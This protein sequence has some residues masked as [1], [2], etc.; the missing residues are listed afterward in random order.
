[1]T[2]ITI[3]FE[4][5]AQSGTKPHCDCC[6]RTHMKNT[7]VLKGEEMAPI[8]LGVI[9]AGKWFGIDLT[10]NT[11]LAAKRFRRHVDGMSKDDLENVLDRIRD[12]HAQ[13]EMDL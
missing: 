11:V 9:C 3:E 4:N 1:M 8:N 5:H 2:K 6:G 12:S 10:G 13:Q 7:Y